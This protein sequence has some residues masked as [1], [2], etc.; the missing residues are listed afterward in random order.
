[1]PFL[2][3]FHRLGALG[4]LGAC[5]ALLVALSGCQVRDTPGNAVRGKQLF[6]AKCGAC[7]TM[8]RAGTQGTIGPNLDAAF[9]RDRVDGFH[10]DTIRGLVREWIEHPNRQGVMPGKLYQGADALDVATYVALVAAH[11]GKDT[12]DLANAIQT[13]SKPAVEKNGT[14]EIDADPS[15]QLRFQA[16]S[17]TGTAGQVT[18]RSVNKSAVGHDISIKGMGIDSHG[19]VVSNGG[20][21]TV[22]A[23]LK[24][25]TY[26]FY[27]SVPGHY[28]P[29]GGK[30]TVK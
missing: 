23:N 1:M 15:G 28:P 5:T 10:S 18:L 7:H 2:R 30:L 3:V 11:K 20:V 25:G 9:A 26:T 27:C 8:R 21:S 4:A 24:P 16:P 13:V 12:G 29:M 17:A 14:L 6:V 22:T 19:K